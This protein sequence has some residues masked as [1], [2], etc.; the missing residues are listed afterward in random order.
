MAK[1]GENIR[2][3]KDGRWEA[4][5][6]KGRR[7]DGRIYYGYVYAHTYDEV[8][9]KK[10]L[11]LQQMYLPKPI[12]NGITMSELCQEWE[13]SMRYTIKESTY[14][15][16]DTLIEKHIKPWF[17]EYKL[18]Q[19]DTDLIMRFAVSKTE[20][21]L[22]KRSV[23]SLLILLQCILR[24]GEKKG[25]LSLRSI[26]ITYP[27]VNGQELRI[28]SEAHVHQLIDTLSNDPSLFSSGIL[29][30]IY[31]GIR[32]GEL[33]GLKWA[34]FDFEKQIISIRRT[35][36]RVKNLEYAE[37]KELPK[38]R[39]LITTPKSQSSLRS[40][41]IPEFLMARLQSQKSQPD[42]FLLTGTAKCME[43]RCIQRRFQYLLEQCGIPKINIHALRHAFATRCTE[44]GFDSKALSEIL[45]HSSA[46]I[47]MDIY[48]HSNLQQKK[49]Y[50]DKLYY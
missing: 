13:M 31:T 11:A 41:P 46:K 27:K 50:L 49:N 45:G 47:T 44:I 20:S 42:T 23:K 43:P 30:C 36:S 25:Y 40:I 3:R 29:I 8:K 12:K 28:I 37:G 10:N 33:S 32:V 35:V 1:R 39:L 38:T 22:S 2:K 24:Y 5:Y 21:G 48:V 16:Y 7:E 9:R 15:C 26:Q 34:D 14:A 18:N 17:S 4:R 6:E 19:V